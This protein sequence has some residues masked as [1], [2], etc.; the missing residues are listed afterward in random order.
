MAQSIHAVALYELRLSRY[1]PP[2]TEKL[3]TAARDIGFFVSHKQLETKI[4]GLEKLH[5]VLAVAAAQATLDNV[6]SLSDQLAYGDLC[7]RALSHLT[8]ARQTDQ[9]LH[10]HR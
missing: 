4:E 10:N 5:G 3:T 8:E 7:D 2:T 1:Y 9:F 6:S